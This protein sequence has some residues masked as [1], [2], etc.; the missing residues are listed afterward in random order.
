MTVTPKKISIIEGSY[1]HHPYFGD[2]YDLKIFLHVSPE[3][4]R[5]RILARPGFLQKRFFE[6][7]VPMEQQYF[8]AF[9]IEE[10][11]DQLA[12]PADNR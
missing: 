8:E 10:K 11:A 6:E 1:S 9:S 4:R 5:Q 7:W 2:P 3:V 12:V